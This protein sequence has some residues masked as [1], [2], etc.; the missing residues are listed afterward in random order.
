LT[1]KMVVSLKEKVDGGFYKVDIKPVIGRTYQRE[2]SL[3][4]LV[5]YI[6]AAKFYCDHKGYDFSYKDFVH[7]LSQQ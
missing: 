7:Y 3:D 4:G 2:F 1:M 5:D 6:E